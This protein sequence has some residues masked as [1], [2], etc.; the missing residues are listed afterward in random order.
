MGP[1]RAFLARR[2]RSA[3]INQLSTRN[4]LLLL[5]KNE[6]WSNGLMHAPSVWAYE[7][8]KFVETLIFS[9]WL[10]RA[11]VQALVMLPKM[12]KKRRRFMSRRQVKA[13]EL[14][15]WFR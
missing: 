8:A 3:W 11:Y 2:R 14:R 9:P 4:H 15:A 7:L 12:L 13:R 10:F 1:W 5:I 6:D